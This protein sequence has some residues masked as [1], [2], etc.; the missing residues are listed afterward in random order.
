MNDLKSTLDNNP[1]NRWIYLVRSNTDW[2]KLLK[3]A[4]PGSTSLKEWLFL[5]SN[6]LSSAPKCAVNE[7]SNLV[8]WHDTHYTQ[9][10]SKSCAQSFK[11]Q[12]GSL[13]QIQEKI[14]QTNLERYGYSNALSN[15][16][17]QNKRIQTNIKKYGAGNSPK[18]RLAAKDRMVT[19]NHNL[20]NILLEKYGVESTQ[21]IPHVREK[22][23]KT[24]REK[25]N[26]NSASAIPRVLEKRQLERI[27]DWEKLTNTVKIISLHDP[28]KTLPFANKKI[29]FQC[30]Q[31]DNIEIL[32]SETFKYRS[33]NFGTPCRKCSGISHGSREETQLF[34]WLNLLGLNMVRNDRSQIAPFELDIFL[35]DQRIA[36]EY[37]GLYW[38]S[39]ENGKSRDYHNNKTQLCE[40]QN[41]RLIQIFQ[42]EWLHQ[43]AVVKARLLHILQINKTEKIYARKCNVIAVDTPK[44][45]EFMTQ[46]HI[47]GFSPSKIHLGLTYN[48]E[49]VSIM[50][51]SNLNAAKGSKN[52]KNHWE[53]TRFASSKSVVGGA[54][55]LFQAFIDR[56]NP[57][58]IIS[59]SDRRWNT[60]RVYEKIGM[61]K[62][63]TTQPNYWYIMG[64]K[65]EYRFK[66]RKDQL[67][68]QGHDQNLTE[69]EIMKS[70]GYL[71]IWD[72]GHDKWIWSKK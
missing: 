6:N 63:T 45:R 31:C 58:Q 52:L 9:C 43:Q 28:V 8:V 47:Q 37:C 71:R 13:T 3:E 14:E 40:E 55:K 36:I 17:I 65:R 34:D 26:V 53:I 32:P 41:I 61:I 21:Q 56:W 2:M 68:K 54:G 19:I 10:C 64:D 25:Y 4:Y 30:I 50:S 27:D 33:R 16:D 38:H 48:D 1:K 7:C 18:A 35:P 42:D 22:T 24:L 12:T 72:C 11:K 66:Y 49:I 29:E 23:R 20:T 60:G 15:P 51:F 39:E 44:V 59:Y 69:K 46:H 5:F 62:G 70:L 67:V 57:H